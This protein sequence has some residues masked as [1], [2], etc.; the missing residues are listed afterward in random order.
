MN[1][2][3]D[4]I[5][6]EILRAFHTHFTNLPPNYQAHLIFFEPFTKEEIN[7]CLCD[8]VLRYND[9]KSHIMEPKHK[10]AVLN[11]SATN[12]GMVLRTAFSVYD[13]QKEDINSD[14]EFPSDDAVVNFLISKAEQNS[15]AI[16]DNHVTDEHDRPAEFKFNFTIPQNDV[17][18]PLTKP[19]ELKLS[20]TLPQ[21]KVEDQPNKQQ[22][23]EY[24]PYVLSIA[25][26]GQTAKASLTI[27]NMS[28]CTIQFRNELDAYCLLCNCLLVIKSGAV[29]GHLK[30]SK[31]FKQSENQRN[32]SMLKSY[33]IGFMRLPFELQAHVIYFRPVTPNKTRCTLCSESIDY[34]LLKWHIFDDVHKTAVL[35]RMKSEFF[36]NKEPLLRY[37]VNIYSQEEQD[38]SD[39]SSNKSTDSPIRNGGIKKNSG[40]RKKL[41]IFIIEDIQFLASA[42]TQIVHDIVKSTTNSE[43]TSFFEQLENRFRSHLNVL[44]EF[45][46]SIFC[47]CCD[48][49]IPKIA[50]L[51]K[52]HL[53]S[54]THKAKIGV[55]NIKYKYVCYVCYANFSREL[56]WQEHLQQELHIRR[57]SSDF[58]HFLAVTLFLLLDVLNYLRVG[59]L[60][61]NV[62][63]V[64]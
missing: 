43:S 62:E 21:D 40:K 4:P 1:N 49:E 53:I 55:A 50:Y 57:Y 54:D 6:R 33:H 13:Y 20:L 23:L 2:A 45:A 11:G 29:K 17:V 32:L 12:E 3:I 41:F 34:S 56:S 37:A 35:V 46:D 38:K 27:D 10:H 48:G 47:K 7:C 61:T 28:F 64:M 59:K 14:T 36:R 8:T 58:L 19:P 18:E 15:D 26:P 60:N 42:E 9:F 5:K 25:F 22:T 24:A 39:E 30:G 16:A 51:V 31:H 44:V 52:K 63:R